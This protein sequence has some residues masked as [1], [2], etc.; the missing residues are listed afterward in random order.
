MKTR[1]LP[2]AGLLIIGTLGASDSTAA[3]TIDNPIS[4]AHI[5][6]IARIAEYDIQLI[7]TIAGQDAI[8]R[9]IL[10]KTIDPIRIEESEISDETLIAIENIIDDDIQADL[11][12]AEIR[13]I[14]A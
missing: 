3:A 9:A 14:A 8:N 5:A 6:G 7:D 11:I 12:D 4:S 10:T 2:L 1:Y 13:D